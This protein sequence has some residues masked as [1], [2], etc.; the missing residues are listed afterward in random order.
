MFRCKA[1]RGDQLFATSQATAVGNIGGNGATFA[2][3]GCEASTFGRRS[4]NNGGPEATS[5]SCATNRAEQ[6]D[7]VI[8]RY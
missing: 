4:Q 8:Q 7:V 6:I 2:A 1:G 5:K 3:R